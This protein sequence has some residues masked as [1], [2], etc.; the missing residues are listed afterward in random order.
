M[1][2]DVATRLAAFVDTAD[3]NEAD[4]RFQIIDQLFADVLGWPRSS[5][6]LEQATVDGYMD[7]HFCRPNGTPALIIEAKRI[8]IYFDIPPNFNHERLYR[9]VKV[10]ALLTSKDLK[11]ALLQAHRY[12]TDEGSE[13]AGVSNGRQLVVFKVFEKGRSWRDL[14]ALVISHISWFVESYTEAVTL[15]GYSSVVERS[16]LRRRFDHKNAAS[17]ELFFCKDKINAFNQIINANALATMLRPIVQ[18]YFGPLDVEDPDFIDN[19]Y[20]NQRAYDKSLKGIRSLIRDAVSPFMATY[21]IAETEDNKRGGAF[22]RRI[23]RGLQRKAAGDVVVLFGGKGSG[24]STFLR[25]VL[26]HEP[27]QYLKK[28]ST[29]IVVDLLGAPKEKAAIRE[30]VWRKLIA[31]LDTEGVL[32]GERDALLRLFEDRWATALRQ[33]LYGFTSDQPI[34]NERLNDLVS[35]WKQ[36][37]RYVAHRL[38]AWHAQHHRGVVL[39]L[40]NTDQF[41]NELQDYSFSVAE[42]MSREFGCM[43]LIS[44]REERFYA[45]KMRGMLDAYQN[46]AFHVSSPSPTEVFQRRLAYVSGLIR[47]GEIEFTH[48]EKQDVLKFLKIFHVDFEREPSSPLNRFISTCAHGNIRLALEIFGELLVSGYTNAREMIDI[49][50]VWTISIHQ[51]L[52]P[53]LIPTRLFYDEKHSRIPDLLQIRFGDG[54]SHFTGL[55]VLRFL[56]RGQDPHSPAYLPLSEIRSY[57]GSVFGNDE[58]LRLWLDRL[59]AANLIEASTRQDYF[60]DEIDALR[61]TS[62]GQFALDELCLMFTYVDLISTDG[63]V[64]DESLCNELVRL[65]NEEVRLATERRR[66]ERVQK[67]LLRARAFLEYLEQEESRELELYGL[68]GDDAFAPTMLTALDNEE[69]RVLASAR[70]NS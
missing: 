11:E 7:Y 70:R 52:R 32:D 64:R 42:E 46:S 62:F 57:F 28:H 15:L 69:P 38:V 5:F 4:T 12:A 16:S 34:F 22:A 39:A 23:T 63:G 26:Q 43:V 2:V 21:G 37:L 61:I 49:D 65:S 1:S 8:G 29:P 41:D 67:R 30:Y 24:K 45:S 20:V 68:S 47:A 51:V 33:D 48:G 44:M 35:A 56:S 6:R 55:R 9:E 50:G 58:D 25:R 60:T 40:D 53:L 3:L 13:Y 18:R 27:P 66:Y 31:L 10:K 14:P 19:C 59:L 17:R 54:G 36:D